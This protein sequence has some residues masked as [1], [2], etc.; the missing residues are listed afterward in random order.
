MTLLIDYLRLIRVPN[1]FTVPSNILVGISLGSDLTFSIHTVMQIIVSILLYMGGVALNDFYDFEVDKKQ[2][3]NRPLSSGRIPKRYALLLAII[4]FGISLLLAYYVSTLG[5]SISILLIITI[6]AYDYKLKDGILGPMIM[7]TARVLNI[8]LGLSTYSNVIPYNSVSLLVLSD[9]FLFI[10]GIS[11]LSRSEIGSH[12]PKLSISVV[13]AIL[14]YIVSSIAFYIYLGL[15]KFD[16]VFSLIIFTTLI[17]VSLVKFYNTDKQQPQKIVRNLIM[18]IIVLDSIFLSGILG[19]I[20]G[21]A[22]LP[23]LVP[24]IILSR[25]IY[26]T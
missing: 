19:L 22:I 12:I 21:L 11:L 24:C 15:L 9:T 6:F 5:F 23:L 2:R 18:A 25:K 7:A 1:L 14:M 26:M 13:L 16:S 17:A 4:A 3:P 20:Y 10:F 8:L